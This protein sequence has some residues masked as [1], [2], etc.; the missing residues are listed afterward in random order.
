M[1]HKPSG[2]FGLSLCIFI[3]KNGNAKSQKAFFDCFDYTGSGC[4]VSPEWG[5]PE[6]AL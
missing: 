5:K 6:Y 3:S 2:L 4:S 1:H